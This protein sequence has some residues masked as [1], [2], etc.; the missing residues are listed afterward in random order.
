[1][2]SVLKRKANASR[3]RTITTKK[4]VPGIQFATKKEKITTR[5]RQP[6]YKGNKKYRVCEV[7][8]MPKG[9]KVKYEYVEIVLDTNKKRLIQVAFDDV[10]DV[11]YINKKY[12]SQKRL[13]VKRKNCNKCI[14][15]RI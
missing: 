6:I 12:T 8:L 3:N 13:N 14:R 11:A 4:T 7:V 9:K 5:Q 1:M 10:G 2:K 15:E